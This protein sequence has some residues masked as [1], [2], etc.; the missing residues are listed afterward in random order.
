MNADVSELIRVLSEKEQEKVKAE[1]LAAAQVKAMRLQV[2]DAAA[3]SMELQRALEQEAKDAKA[4]F[5]K[6]LR[7]QAF[8][9]K[10]RLHKELRSQAMAQ[11]DA[12]RA[13]MRVMKTQDQCYKL[14]LKIQDLQIYLTK[15][16][17]KANLAL[18]SLEEH[19][20]ERIERVQTQG[21]QRSNRMRRHTLETSVHLGV[22]LDNIMKCCK[23]QMM[24]VHRRAEGHSRFKELCKLAETRDTYT[25]SRENYG[26]I[27]V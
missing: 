17:E 7:E 9:C 20:S 1:R 16:T 23:E 4:Q 6:A 27:K 26:K 24:H 25:M 14:G 2:D 18:H 11:G 19:L 21:E 15:Q 22:Q 10:A 8:N 12:E 13:R 3:E 5:D